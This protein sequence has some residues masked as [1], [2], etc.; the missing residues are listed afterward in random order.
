MCEWVDGKRPHAQRICFELI[1]V[2]KK[3][4][5]CPNRVKK[6]KKK[7]PHKVNIMSGTDLGIPDLNKAGV[8]ISDE[9]FG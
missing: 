8:F 3:N 6:K 4:T 1:K 2:R 5:H 9:Y 7:Q